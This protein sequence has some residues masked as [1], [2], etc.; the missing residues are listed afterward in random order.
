MSTKKNGW[1]KW[2]AIIFLL[3][4]A[5][6]LFIFV[7]LPKQAFMQGFLESWLVSRGLVFY[8]DFG[9]QYLPFLRLLMIPIHNIF[10]LNQYTT[11]ALA[12]I[13]TVAVLYLLFLA[14]R[15]WLEGWFS[16]IPIVFFSIW[17]TFL[18]NNHFLATSF[19]GLTVLMS[20]I[21][22]ISWW[23]RPTLKKSFLIGLLSAA[24]I[25]TMQIVLPFL[26]ILNVSLFLKFTK[27]RI[28]SIAPHFLALGAGFLIPTLIISI[29][30]L[31]KGALTDLY[32]LTIKY[33]LTNYPYASLGRETESIFVFLSIHLP[34]IIVLFTK[35][36]L[37]KKISLF[38]SLLLLPL[39]FWFAIFHPIRFEISLPAFALVFGIATQGLMKNKTGKLRKTGIGLLSVILAINLFTILKYKVESY[40]V[41]LFETKYLYE[42]ISEVYPGDPMYTSIEWMKK[43]SDPQEKI[44]VLADALFYIKTDRLPANRRAV[45]SEAFVY[46][47]FE[48]FK[49][50]IQASWPAY[51]VIDERQWRRMDDFGYKD[52][53][54][55]FQKLVEND[56]VVAQFDYWTIRKHIK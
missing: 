25:F 55:N 49:S 18:S 19:L 28:K 14:G 1:Y 30:F 3:A 20:V 48:D 11:I 40:K 29:W 4:V 24:S 32:N 41:K 5:W 6:E 46:V 10:G 13:T 37:S 7:T 44:F 38:F 8:K 43:N 15:K 2:L 23:E 39:A 42:I 36:K 17:H 27:S 47:P 16:L 22:W 53:R 56:P 45:A 34:V 35:F 31:F 51:W 9:G 54:T 50:E 52:L 33:H 26:V 12:P 21:L